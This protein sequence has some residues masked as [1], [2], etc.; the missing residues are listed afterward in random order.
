MDLLKIFLR[1]PPQYPTNFLDAAL[2][3][4]SRQRIH[5][6]DLD[7]LQL[8]PPLVPIQDAKAFV[9][10]TLRQPF[11]DMMVLRE[12]VKAHGDNVKGQL[13]KLENQRVIVTDDRMYDA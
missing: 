5:L 4:I 8:L 3:L 9:Y 7:A 1:P 12:V 10:D 13:M 11:F 2:G 6:D